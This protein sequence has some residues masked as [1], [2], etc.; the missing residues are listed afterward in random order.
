MA[1]IVRHWDFLTESITPVAVFPEG[2]VH[3]STIAQALVK[4]FDSCAY[5]DPEGAALSFITSLGASK[6]ITLLSEGRGF[7]VYYWSF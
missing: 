7:A 2:T 6:L 4:R 1:T 5:V 3:N